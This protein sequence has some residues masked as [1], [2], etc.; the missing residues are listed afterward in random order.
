[1]KKIY[2]N[3]TLRILGKI[4]QKLERV[5][6]GLYEEESNFQID[7]CFECFGGVRSG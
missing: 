7:A 3:V 1:M 2:N 4:W 6:L 5:E